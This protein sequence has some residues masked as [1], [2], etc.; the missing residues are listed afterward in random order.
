MKHKPIEVS[1]ADQVFGGRVDD[2]LPAWKDIPEEFKNNNHPWCK[3]QSDWF[4]EGLKKYPVPND[5][6]DLDSALSN[7]ACVQGSWSPKHE[8]KVA[9]VA[10]LASLWFSS[11]DGEEIKQP[12]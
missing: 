9:G 5:G 3:W 12:A 6:V 11:P 7:L 10:Y 8:H 1:K 4:Y 2:I